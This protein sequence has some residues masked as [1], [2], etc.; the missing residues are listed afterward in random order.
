MWLQAKGHNWRKNKKICLY[1]Q[2]NLMPFLSRFTLTQNKQTN[3]QKLT[4]IPYTVTHLHFL[5]LTI[6]EELRATNRKIWK[7]KKT[8]SASS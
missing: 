8:L 7:G 2:R 6:K 5:E 3:K 1:L 4:S